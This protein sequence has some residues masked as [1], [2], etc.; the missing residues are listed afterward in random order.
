M[1]PYPVSASWSV[2]NSVASFDPSNTSST[3]ITG[4]NQGEAN[5]TAF[6]G[7]WERYD[8]DGL[9]CVDLG[10]QPESGGGPLNVFGIIT[11]GTV[12]AVPTSINSSHNSEVSVTL[13]ASS[14]TNNT[15]GTM[16]SL[17]ITDSTGT[18]QLTFEPTQQGVNLTSGQTKTFK[19]TVTLQSGS[20]TCKFAAHI[21]VGSNVTVTNNDMVKSESVT[22]G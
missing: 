7:Y 5:L 10:P 18:H 2:D 13:S 11:V 19:F 21:D 20:G 1:G 6:V 3:T 14:N 17:L 8:F 9:N 12:V 4:T 15:N 16:V 22:I